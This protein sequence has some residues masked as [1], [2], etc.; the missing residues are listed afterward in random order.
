MSK[1]VVVTASNNN[2]LKLANRFKEISQELGASAEIIDLV[3]L[4]LPLYSPLA[5]EKG[6]PSNIKAPIDQ[7]MSTDKLVFITPEYN[8]GI[9]PTLNNFIA[10][11]SRAGGE[12]WRSAFNNK[13]AIIGTFSGGGGLHALA[14][15]RSQLAYVGVNVMGRQVAANFKKPDVDISIKAC[16]EHLLKS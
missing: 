5:E 13:S 9:A 6:M 16:L 10:W 4:D 11:V 3:A 14:A 12:D 15:L 1:I 8:G 2:N 7:L